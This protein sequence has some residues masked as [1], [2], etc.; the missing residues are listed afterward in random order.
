MHIRELLSRGRNPGIMKNTELRKA[1][2][3]VLSFF[4]RQGVGVQ[5]KDEK[6][7]NKRTTR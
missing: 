7:D 1:E 5:N 4:L 2:Y 6:R 3:S